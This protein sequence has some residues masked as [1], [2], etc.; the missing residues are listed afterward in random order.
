MAVILGSA[1]IETMMILR[2][3]TPIM[4]MGSVERLVALIVTVL[5]KGPVRSARRRMAESWVNVKTD[6]EMED[7]A[8]ED[9]AVEDLDM[10]DLAMED[11]AVEDLY[12]ED[13]EAEDLKVENQCWGFPCTTDSD[14][15]NEGQCSYRKYYGLK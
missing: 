13:L 5:I 1:K 14:C 6:A 15:S 9:L 12:M 8:V 3:M 11:L 7:L 2:T 10:E 4:M